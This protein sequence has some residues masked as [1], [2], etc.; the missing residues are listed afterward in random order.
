MAGKYM[1]NTGNPATII[2]I[3]IIIITITIILKNVRFKVT[4]ISIGISVGFSIN[5]SINIGGFH[6]TQ[7]TFFYHESEKYNRLPFNILS[8]EIAI[9]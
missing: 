7:I 1:N 2:I 4:T 8:Q 9:S 5:I 3:I 6:V